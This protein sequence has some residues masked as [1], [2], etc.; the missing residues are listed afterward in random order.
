MIDCFSDL[1]ISYNQAIHDKIIKQLG[2]ILRWRCSALN[3]KEKKALFVCTC[4]LFVANSGGFR[5]SFDGRWNDLELAL[6]DR[7]YQLWI[8]AVLGLF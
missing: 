3:Y 4:E 1:N 2:P 6:G 8:I 7:N 5:C